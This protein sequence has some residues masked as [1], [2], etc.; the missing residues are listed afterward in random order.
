MMTC[1]V[2]D[3]SK[4]VQLLNVHTNNISVCYRTITFLKVFINC[5]A[6]L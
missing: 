1:L 3:C 4:R 2:S 6:V 5:D